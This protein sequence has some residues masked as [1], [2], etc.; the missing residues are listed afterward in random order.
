MKLICNRKIVLVYL[1]VYQQFF[2][3]FETLKRILIHFGIQI[4]IVL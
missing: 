3:I 1:L 2:F 4:N